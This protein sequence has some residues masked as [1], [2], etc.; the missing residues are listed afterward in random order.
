[1]E[2]RMDVSGA[3][4][5]R[6]NIEKVFQKNPLYDGD[7]GRRRQYEFYPY[8]GEAKLMLE[9]ENPNN[10]HAVIVL[11][12]NKKI[13]Y[14]PDDYADVIFDEI[15]SNR[16]IG[17]TLE[18]KGGNYADPDGTRI[19][20]RTPSMQLSVVCEEKK[21]ASPLLLICVFGGFIGAHWFY[22][23][24]YKKG[25]LYLLTAGLFGI[26]WIIDIVKIITGRL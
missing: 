11:V 5:N 13:G 24:N 23:K 3:F 6:E 12:D 2:Y 8:S 10:P 20:N 19:V 7:P 14:V 22:L 1:M 4:Y 15:T 25:I 26:G 9:P 18:M 21:D 16:L 17:A